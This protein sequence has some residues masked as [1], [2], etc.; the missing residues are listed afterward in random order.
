MSGIDNVQHIVATIRAEM[1]ARISASE[2]RAG[3]QTKRLARNTST[4]LAQRQRMGSLIG[5]RV[6]S[7][8]PDDPKR[9][10]KAF[11]IFLESVLLSEFGDR[12]I[13][14]HAFYQMIDAVEQAMEQDERI[15]AA[16]GKAVAGLFKDRDAGR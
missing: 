3:A 12:L 13:N 6:K 10:K 4:A 15:S 2:P 16:I 9:G 11:R 14:D 7:L 8:D 5:Q 1:A